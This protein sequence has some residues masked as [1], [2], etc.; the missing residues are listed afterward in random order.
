MNRVV[1]WLT[2]ISRIGRESAIRSR[3]SPTLDFMIDATEVLTSAGGGALLPVWTGTE[4]TDDVD[5]VAVFGRRLYLVPTAFREQQDVH[6]FVDSTLS[7][8]FETNLRLRVV[9]DQPV[10]DSPVRP[11]R[12]RRLPQPQRAARGAALRLGS[13]W[14]EVADLATLAIL[15][16][17][18]DVADDPAEYPS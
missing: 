17:V 6:R 13:F 15:G 9:G 11:P 12:E 10:A 1:C 4:F 5:F 3:D 18:L 16:E 7:A 14:P 2:G 8:R